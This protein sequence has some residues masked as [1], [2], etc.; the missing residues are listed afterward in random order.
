MGTSNTHTN[1]VKRIYRKLGRMWRSFK[2]RA[3]GQ[4]QSAPA[5][6]EPKVLTCK[7]NLPTGKHPAPIIAAC[8]YV[9]HPLPTSAVC[10]NPPSHYLGANALDGTLDSIKLL[11]GDRMPKMEE[12]ELQKSFTKFER[13]YRT[14]KI[15]D[16]ND[17][18]LTVYFCDWL[19]FANPRGFSHD[20][21]FDFELYNK[22]PK[23]RDTFL[24]EGYRRHVRKVC[25][26][27]DARSL[28]SNKGKFNSTFHE[29]VKR[30]WLDVSTCTFEEFQA[31]AKKH[32]SC[33]AKPIC[34]TGGSGARI[35][36]LTADTVE[37]LYS[38][39]KAEGLI[40]EEVIKQHPALAEF[41]S[42]TLN[43][44]RINT[45]LCADGTS[46]VLLAV[47]R[48]GRSGNVV[49][50]FHCGGVAAIVDVETGKII[51]T[52]IDRAHQSTAIH[53]DSQK[54]FLGFQFPEWEK[55]VD[56]VC[57]A[58]K[59]VPTL[60]HVGWDVA[61]TAEGNVEFVEGNS[62]PNFDVL[63]SPDQVGR[64]FRYDKYIRELEALEGMK[65]KK[66]KALV[67]D[68]QGM[69]LDGQVPQVITGPRNHPNGKHPAPIIAACYYVGHPLPT[70]A[71]CGNPPSHYLGAN[72]LD[73]TLDSIKLLL[74]DRMPKMEE[75]EL[76]KSFTKFERKY[77][78]QKILD[79]ND[80]DLTVY[81][82]D[83][84]LFANPR[85]FSHDNYFDFELYN[86]EPKIRDTF[87]NEGYRRHVRKVCNK[88]DARSLL[89][90]KGK[91]NSTFHEF[92][93]RDW[94]DVSTCTFEEF[95]AF[96]KKHD[97]C[98]AKPIC[99]TGGSGARILDL[100]ADTVENLYS[101]CKAEG[102]IVEEVIKQHPALAEFNSSTLN[103]VRINTL[104]CADGTSR[105][106]LAVSRFGRSGNVVDN[107]H[108]GGVAAIVDV[109]TGKIISTAIDRAHQSTAIHPDSQKEFLGFQFP[110]WE[111]VVDSVCRAAKLVPTLRHVGWD[112]AVTAEGNV[113]F[114]E[115]NSR[116]N[117]DV[118]QS[119]DQVGRLFRYDKYIRE[120]EALEGMKHKKRKALVLDIQGMEL[121]GQVQQPEI[122]CAD[123]NA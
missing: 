67:L 113:E 103:T 41:N 59:L 123:E 12:E 86:K 66:R 29:F 8:Y 61:V 13:K 30:D 71:V 73:G 32:D 80:T 112:V 121:D 38:L 92:V 78:T 27:S 11:L 52:A 56:S 68:I 98:F 107:F 91:F 101:L 45:L 81:F 115:G 40:V 47:S 109:E 46:R 105:V 64:L 17:T 57:R 89:S 33:F 69:E 63:Q 60:R 90:N 100:T 25:N 74:G 2:Y 88:S 54:E 39:C 21:Y 9:G 120:L 85:G 34:G 106:L 53:P 122:P 15:L 65:H 72:A 50:N 99:G 31:F 76:Q 7:S 117:F 19:L 51:S 95:Q 42:S 62:R 79:H 110:E 16:H 18:D 36:D 83:W 20:N 58:A 114:V 70:S 93:K 108:C 77:R 49:D 6:K 1:T 22:E 14:Q 111:K 84:L 3:S 118:L 23:I 28:L 5:A 82:C 96:A 10:G 43:T 44:V 4:K 35:L 104:L 119:P 48:F 116:P 24:N 94:L 102:L 55:V 75:E 37:N 26:K 87:L 97:S